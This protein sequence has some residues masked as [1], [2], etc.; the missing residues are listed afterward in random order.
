MSWMLQYILDYK[1]TLVQVLQSAGA[2]RHQ[3]LTGTNVNQNHVTP[4]G[5][6]GPQL[7]NMRNVNDLMGILGPQSQNYVNIE[8]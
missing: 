2:V 6:S 3:G 7:V 8:Q 5:V 1:P 4:S